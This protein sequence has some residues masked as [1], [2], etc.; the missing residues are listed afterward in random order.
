MHGRIKQIRVDT[1][2][3]GSNSPAKVAF[4][5]EASLLSSGFGL[6]HELMRR[7]EFRGAKPANVGVL[8]A[9]RQGEFVRGDSLG[10]GGGSGTPAS[11]SSVESALDALRTVLQSDIPGGAQPSHAS[12]GGIRD[13]RDAIRSGDLTARAARS[14]VRSDAA[15]L[16]SSGL[17]TV[18]IA[19]IQS[20]QQA[21]ASDLGANVANATPPSTESTIASTNRSVS[22]YL[23]GAGAPS[24]FGIRGPGAFDLASSSCPRRMN[25][26]TLGCLDATHGIGAAI[27]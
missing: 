11:T 8:E 5:C 9:G 1:R 16:S 20:D 6:R 17:L 14:Q 15:V 26:Q 10:L 4:I 24:E 13:D 2:K 18:E 27:P 3:Y 25:R 7:I 12:I 22:A 19:P 21:L 23:V